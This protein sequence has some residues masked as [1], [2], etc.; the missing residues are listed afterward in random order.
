M[1]IYT[2][3]FFIQAKFWILNITTQISSSSVFK[4]YKWRNRKAITQCYSS[5]NR[6][7]IKNFYRWHRKEHHCHRS[8][9]HGDSMLIIT[10]HTTYLPLFSSSMY[11]SGRDSESTSIELLYTLT[12]YICL[13]LSISLT[14]TILHTLSAYCLFIFHDKAWILP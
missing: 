7:N 12:Q 9:C 1:Y 10:K 11:V 13:L 6:R 8:F 14:C 3:L 5:S 2:S 4:I